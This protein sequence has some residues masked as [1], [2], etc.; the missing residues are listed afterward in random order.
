VIGVQ[1]SFKFY[2]G[3]IVESNAFD[4]LNGCSAIIQYKTDRI[5]R[6]RRIVFDPG[7]TFLLRRGNDTPIRKQRGR[8][9]VVIGGN[10]ED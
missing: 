6:E 4:I 1:K 5:S 7:E 8:A 2:V 10:A 9:V 3:F